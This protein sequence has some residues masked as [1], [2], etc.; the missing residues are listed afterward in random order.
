MRNYGGETALAKLPSDRRL[1]VQLSPYFY[2]WSLK[3]LR[4]DLEGNR[5]GLAIVEVAAPINAPTLQ[6]VLDR[7]TL[8]VLAFRAAADPMWWGF[9]EDGCPKSLPGGSVGRINGR[10]HYSWLGLP[11]RISMLPVHLLTH[12]AGA[13][14]RVS[15]ETAQCIVLLLFLI[16]EALRFDSVMLEGARY[17]SG[18]PANVMHPARFRETV[19]GWEKS[20]I[21]N[22]DVLLRHL[23]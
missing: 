19:H 18:I 14:G 8:Y 13:K 17:L 21:D 22:R 11:E 9:L 4:S 20:P 10:S 7:R 23:P 16:P 6:V 3:R 12:L 15:S 2:D 1:H 5:K